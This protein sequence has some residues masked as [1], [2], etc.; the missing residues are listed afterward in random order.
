MNYLSI[1]HASKSFGEKV[2][3]DD[4]TLHINQGDKVAL[5]AQNGSG[6]TTLLRLISGEE[7]AE[8]EQAS[9]FIHKDVR[10]GYLP[11]DPQFR[12]GDTVIDAIFNTENPV[13]D[14]V[15]RYESALLHPNDSE[16]LQRAMSAME[17]QKAWDVEATIKEVLFKLHITELE[18][19]VA[20][21]S[22]GQR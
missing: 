10:L 18:Q 6:K 5:V 14:A 11:Q 17:D 13:L 22:G 21:L 2:L 4:I 9:V 3:L 7:P 15:R 19:P 20:Q 16:R 1:E 12:A 8:G